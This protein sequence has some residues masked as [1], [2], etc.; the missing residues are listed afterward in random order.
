MMTHELRRKCAC[1]GSSSPCKC[2]D[3]QTK[4]QR[5]ASGQRTSGAVPPIVNRVL[6][7][8]GR[9]LDAATRKQF[10]PRFGADFGAVRIHDDSRANE[11]ARAVNA[12][13]YTVGRDMVFATGR[14]APRTTA[15]A[16]LLA[17]ELTHV[18]QKNQIGASSIDGIS[19]ENDPAEIEA[20]HV[21]NGF[22]PR[23]IVS[24]PPALCRQVATD[25]KDV[26]A[27]TPRF[28]VTHYGCFCGKGSACPDGCPAIDEL[29]ECC[30]LH[31]TLYGPCEFKSRD[32][33]SECCEITSTADILLRDCADRVL[34]HAT[35]DKAK[36]ARKVKVL[37]SASQHVPCATPTKKDG[38]GKEAAAKRGPV[39]EK[40]RKE[41]R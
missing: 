4:L 21:A 13:A 15:G 41:A 9:P 16:K 10:E 5:N 3:E 2:N 39:I 29:D 30:R 6:A 28:D 32:P 33:F 18:V 19:S 17:H 25:T 7:S 31:D 26:P 12:Y 20:D 38:G 11:S 24:R 35:G 34:K 8:P 37:F 27:C 22:M 1:G 14:Y 23:S 36:F 40:L